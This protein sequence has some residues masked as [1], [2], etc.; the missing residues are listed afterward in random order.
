VKLRR[1]NVQWIVFVFAFVILLVVVT[2]ENYEYSKANPGGNDF[3][4]HWMGTRTFIQEGISPYSDQTALR[5]QQLAYGRP[6]LPG[7]HELRVAYPLYSIVLFLPFALIP[8]FTLARALWM[9]VLEVGLIALSFISM[10]LTD[11]KP[12]FP[13]LVFFLIFSVMWYHGFRPLINGNVVI[14]VALGFAGALLAFRLG[15]DELAGVLIAFTSIKPQLALLITLYFTIMAIYRKR[16]RFIFW[17]YG[18]LF[19]LSLAVTLLLP[20]W[21][22]QNIREVLRYPGY[23]PPGT[24]QAAIGVWL[25]AIGKRTGQGI[26]FLLCVILIIE[27]WSAR[28][29]E[30]RGFLWAACLTL[31]ISQWIG[32]Q[33]DPGNFI[34]LFPGLILVFAVLE[35]R[36]RR[37]GEIISLVC[38]IL[39]LSGIWALF[40]TT[41]QYGPQPQQSPIMF[42]PLPGLL[43]ALLYWVRWWARRPLHV[44]YEWLSTQDTIRRQ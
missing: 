10:R 17:L 3:L 1:N 24:L 43:L 28:R 20:D 12:R 34:I 14:L 30:F 42:I 5:I 31:V 21:L 2:W 36:W 15:F 29:S 22:I 39:L 13:T 40:L 33:T 25:P 38:L 18:T 41:V 11:W 26:T 9:T 27:W 4:V 19:L 8:D 6:A 37:I 23:N 44:W 35:E 16:W 32:I 7:E